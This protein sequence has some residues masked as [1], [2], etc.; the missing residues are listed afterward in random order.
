MRD[1]IAK[2]K[3]YFGSASQFPLLVVVSSQEYPEVLQAYPREKRSTSATI[4]SGMIRNRISQNWKKVADRAA[5]TPC[6]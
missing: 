4:V 1:A 3:Q 5:G 6:S 2:I